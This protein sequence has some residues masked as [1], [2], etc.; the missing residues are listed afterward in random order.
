[1]RLIY[2]IVPIIAL[3]WVLVS[4]EQEQ[5]QQAEL[6]ANICLPIDYTVSS[7]RRIM[8]DPGTW[9]VFE[10]PKYVYIF[11]LKQVGSEWSV[12]KRDERILAE[13]KWKRT[14]YYGL[15]DTRGDSIFQYEE[16]IRYFLVGEKIKGRVFAICSNKKLTF[17][18]TMQSINDLEDVL[19]WQFSTAPDSIQKNLQNIY[20]TPYNYKHNDSYY[21]SFDCL[22]G[23]SYTID[24]LLYHVAAKVDITWYVAEEKRTDPATLVRLTKMDALELFNGNA[25]CFRPMRNELA[26]IQEDGYD[27]ENIVTA[28]DA[29]LWWEGRTYFYTIP[30]IV[31]GTTV[32]GKNYFPLQMK[33]E[34]NGSG[35]YYTPTLNL[36]I[37]TSAVFVPW[38]RANFNINAALSAGSPTISVDN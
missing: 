19:N 8:G 37:D 3:I 25:Y 6:Y 12:W 27:R 20:S 11:V 10:F 14:R 17:S 24:L 32:D 16:K 9:E 2:R 7:P 36:K 18:N 31:T 1:M 5:E 23:N 38:L 35:E 21:C 4:C 26:A 30:Y 34:T 22:D 15:H 28:T 29:G 13:D 33:M